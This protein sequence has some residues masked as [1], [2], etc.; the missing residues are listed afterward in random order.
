MQVG[1]F[2]RIWI[3]SIVPIVSE[4]L[5]ARGLR[6]KLS[7]CA[8]FKSGSCQDKKF[9]LNAIFIFDMAKVGFRIFSRFGRRNGFRDAGNSNPRSILVLI[10]PVTFKIG[11]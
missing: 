2:S 4:G 1:S 11:H 3:G 6:Y 8:I 9:E 7:F 10:G 5:F